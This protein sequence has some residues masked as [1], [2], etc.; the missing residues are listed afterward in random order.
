MQKCRGIYCLPLQ[1]LPDAGSAGGRNLSLN[2]LSLLLPLQVLPDAG[3]AGGRSLPPSLLCSPAPYA[4][5]RRRQPSLDPPHD[6]AHGKSP[7]L[8]EGS[9]S[10]R[11]QVW[12]LSQTSASLAAQRAQVREPSQRQRA[13]SASTARPLHILL[14]AAPPPVGRPGV[15]VYTPAAECSPKRQQLFEVARSGVEGISVY[16]GPFR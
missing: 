13:V 3:S 15:P 1:V 4:T 5:W 8:R 11:A 2:A 14:E 6:D 10:P 9:S 16:P 12:D 7:L